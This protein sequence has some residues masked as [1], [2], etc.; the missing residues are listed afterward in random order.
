LGKY[1]AQI[2]LH[3]DVNVELPFEIIAEKA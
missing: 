1:S 2:R 3:R